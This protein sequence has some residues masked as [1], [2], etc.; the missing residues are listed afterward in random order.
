MSFNPLDVTKNFLNQSV[1]TMS[2]TY[3]KVS[4]DVANLITP[5]VQ[6]VKPDVITSQPI[7]PTQPTQP[8][9]PIQQVKSN[10][11][12]QTQLVP[13]ESQY[14]SQYIGCYMDD[15]ANPSMNTFL[16]KVSNISECIDMGKNKNFEYV[17]IRGG[18]ECLASNSIPTTQSVNRFKYC[19]VGCDEM[20]T[21]NCGGFF[22]NQVYKTTIP[23]N[24]KNNKEITN[25]TVNLLEKFISSDNDL[26]KISIGLGNDNFNCWKPI[27]I[28]MIF[29][30][31]VILLFLIYLLF[32]YLRNKKNERLI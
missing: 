27:N 25:E 3:D 29:I 9:Q 20:G 22:Y 19:N 26:K 7:Q 18:N 32:E 24:S 31:L 11:Q 10:E 21:G 5:I 2:S 4:V 1:N 8:T 13:F 12:E 30:W 16:G 14:E 28:Y 6:T 17:G 23:I 15:P